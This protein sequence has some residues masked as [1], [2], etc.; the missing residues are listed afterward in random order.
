MNQQAIAELVQVND[1]MLAVQ[2][3]IIEATRSFQEELAE[4]QAQDRKLR[5]AIQEGFE[6]SGEKNYEDDTIKLV[7]V[8]PTTRKGID[9][10]KLKLLEPEVYAKFEKITNVKGSVRITLK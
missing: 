10:A 2:A 6:Q 7:Y 5:D 9:T 4:Y 1:N 3:Q 8:A